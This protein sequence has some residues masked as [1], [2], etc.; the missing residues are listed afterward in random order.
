[1]YHN[2]KF[3]IL[4][5]TCVWLWIF[6][7]Q[8]DIFN[9][10]VE[11]NISNENT[12]ENINLDNNPEDKQESDNIVQREQNKETELDI[13][14]QE[15]WEDIKNEKYFSDFENTL[16]KFPEILEYP[17]LVQDFLDFKETNNNIRPINI[18]LTAYQTLL[19]KLIKNNL[20]LEIGEKKF[21][22]NNW[23]KY[24]IFGNK[25][26]IKIDSQNSCWLNEGFWACFTVV[27]QQNNK[28]KYIYSDTGNIK[29]YSHKNKNYILSETSFGSWCSATSNYMIYDLSWIFVNKVSELI[30]GCD[31]VTKHWLKKWNQSV[32]FVQYT[33]NR[34]DY[35]ENRFS[36]I[37]I[38]QGFDIK[39]NILYTT[40]NYDFDIYENLFNWPFIDLK[41]N[42]QNKRFSEKKYPEDKKIS[43]SYQ[44]EIMLELLKTKIWF[45][46][47]WTFL[48]E[49]NIDTIAVKNC[50]ENNSDLDD[51]YYTLNK[52]TPWDETFQY[53]ISKEYGNYCEQ[54]SY[55]FRFQW[56]KTTQ[57]IAELSINFE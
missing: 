52:Y 11:K 45:T 26:Y 49:K 12:Q 37:E 23:K 50:K 30:T 9:N 15:F 39:E 6:I 41:I 57:K 51:E 42:G 35:E 29:L 24:A 10:S 46:V 2:I 31:R 56:D 43:Y 21:W 20:L 18:D 7:Y 38:S 19:E 33:V 48:R 32:E 44:D 3:F 4:W 22:S 16:V 5:M 53:N 27:T 17:D 54:G 25:N 1:M 14:K 55:I 36:S 28:Q 8:F 40:G 34:D 47:E 13:D